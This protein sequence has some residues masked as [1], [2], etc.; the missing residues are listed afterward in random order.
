MSEN[1]I[2]FVRIRVS[3]NLGNTQCFGGGL[4]LSVKGGMRKQ[5]RQKFD[6]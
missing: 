4:L 3:R 6:V 5:G 2:F 1:Q